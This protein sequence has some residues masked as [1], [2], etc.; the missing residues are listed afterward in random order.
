VYPF[1]W[2]TNV[3]SGVIILY[4]NNHYNPSR[5]TNSSECINYRNIQT[6]TMAVL[7]IKCFKRTTTALQSI[8][9]KKKTHCIV[10]T[11]PNMIVKSKR[12]NLYT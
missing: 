7:N 2:Y 4:A 12:Q 10:E 3:L 5:Q 1:Y 9:L 6:P 11:V 8:K